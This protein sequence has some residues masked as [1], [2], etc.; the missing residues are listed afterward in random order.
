M[1]NKLKHLEFLQN[2]ITRKNTNSFYIKGWAVTIVAAL[3]ALAT[4]DSEKSF[5]FVAALISFSFWILDAFFLQQERAFRIL[6]SSVSKK[7]NSDIDFSMEIDDGGFSGW[8][9][10]A[11]S[12]T[13][14]AFYGAIG[15]AILMVCYVVS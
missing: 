5:L 9:C 14:L 1:E 10:A 12:R 2:V 15:A 7:I 13:F 6:Y 8:M 11:V 4:K 3:F